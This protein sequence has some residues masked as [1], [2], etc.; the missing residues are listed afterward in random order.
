[1]LGGHDVRGVGEL[2]ARAR[3]SG[4]DLASATAA[5]ANSCAFGCVR[6]DLRARRTAASLTAAA[7]PDGL[8]IIDDPERQS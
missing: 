8:G 1:M 3:P 7:S 2:I 5:R 6:D 4:W